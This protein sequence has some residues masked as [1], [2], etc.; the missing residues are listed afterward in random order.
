MQINAL[1]LLLM[2]MM[3]KVLIEK[4]YIPCLLHLGFLSVL[5]EKARN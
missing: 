4:C 1:F 2:E 5:V 3:D